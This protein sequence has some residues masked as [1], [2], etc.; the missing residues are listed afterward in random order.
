MVWKMKFCF[1]IGIY[2]A[3]R[4]WCMKFFSRD[5]VK[6]STSEKIDTRTVL[7]FRIVYKKI[8]F[9]AVKI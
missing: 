3:K 5:P 1:G 6:G 9:V 4:F 7:A 8:C 2:G